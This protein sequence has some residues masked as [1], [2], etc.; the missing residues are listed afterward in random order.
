MLINQVAQLPYQA[1]AFGGRQL[2]PWAVVK[3]FA[4]GLHCEINVGAIAFS[5]LRQNFAGGWIVSWKSLAGNCVNPLIVNEH[6]AR[7]LNEAEHARIDLSGRNRRHGDLLNSGLKKA[8]VSG[9]CNAI[10]L[11]LSGIEINLAKLSALN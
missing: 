4:R 9:R 8:F 7:L 11:V 3:C 2:A 10:M 6:F 5:N 1:A